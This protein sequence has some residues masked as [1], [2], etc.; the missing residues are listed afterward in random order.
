MH[1]DHP[2]GDSVKTATVQ[3]AFSPMTTQSFVC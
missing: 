3:F 1:S 2:S